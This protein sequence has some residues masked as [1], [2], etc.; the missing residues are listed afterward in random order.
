MK[1]ITKST[2]IVHLQILKDLLEAN[3][4]PA[5]VK[6]ENTARMIS[7]FLITEPSLWVYLDEQESD[8]EK[9]ILDPSY[10]VA[11]KIDVEEFYRLTKDVS[12]NPKKLHDTLLNWTVGLVVV[13]IALILL[14]KLFGE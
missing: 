3:G 8:A 14:P 5:I 13:M 6:G 11:N 4:I 2:D 1:F 12:E 9:L 10:E 7:P